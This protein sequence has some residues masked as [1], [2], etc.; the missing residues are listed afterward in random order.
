MSGNWKN[1]KKIVFLIMAVLFFSGDLRAEPNIPQKAPDGIRNINAL[2][3]K[4]R[5]NYPNAEVLKV[6]LHR[7]DARD[8]PTWI[9][10]V[11]LFPP[12]GH[13]MKL[14]YDAQTLAFLGA[15]GRYEA[16]HPRRRRLRRRRGWRH[17]DWDD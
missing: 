7:G 16:G 11:K 4:V 12:D 5:K 9:Y 14:A 3:V 17:G 2:L 6:E 8:T 10:E 13:I 15:Y 1:V